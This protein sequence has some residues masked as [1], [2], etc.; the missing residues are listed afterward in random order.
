MLPRHRLLFVAVSKA[1]SWCWG[2]GGGE[3]VLSGET[4]TLCLESPRGRDRIP[5]PSGCCGW[6]RAHLPRHGSGSGH[7]ELLVRTQDSAGLLAPAQL[8][9]AC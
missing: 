9:A 4:F 6:V 5:A 8:C 3:L 2:G 1:A 7:E